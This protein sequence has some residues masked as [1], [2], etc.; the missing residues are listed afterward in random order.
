MVQRRSTFQNRAARADFERS[1]VQDYLRSQWE[2]NTGRTWSVSLDGK[3]ATAHHII[4]LESGGENKWWN[5][6]RKALPLGTI[7]DL[8]RP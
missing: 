3:P 1:G 2:A 5:L 6:R 4:P 7:T 8:R